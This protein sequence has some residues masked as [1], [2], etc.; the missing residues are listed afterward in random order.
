MSVFTWWQSDQVVPPDVQV[1]KSLQLTHLSRQS[2][3]LIAAHILRSER[4]ND[5]Q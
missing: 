4:D 5:N 1:S 2:L 3:D